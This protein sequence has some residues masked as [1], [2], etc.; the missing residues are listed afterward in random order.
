MAQRAANHLEA[1]S[2]ED[3]G[4]VVVP[5]EKPCPVQ[6]VS[7]T[8]DNLMAVG[9]DQTAGVQITLS[10]SPVQGGISLQ[11]STT[12]G[13]GSAKFN[14]NN[15]T[16]L[17]ISQT[18]TVTIKGVT[19]SSTANNIRLQAK[20]SDGS[21]TYA[22]KDFTVLQ[23]TLA[24]RDGS[25]GNVTSDNSG[26]VTYVIVLGSLTL[27]TFQSSGSGNHLW[28]TGVEIVGTVEPSNY[29][30]SITIQLEISVI[31]TF[32]DMSLKAV[33]RG[34]LAHWQFARIKARKIYELMTI[35]NLVPG[36]QRSMILMLQPLVTSGS[37]PVNTILRVRTNFRQWATVK[38][39]DGLSDVRVSADKTWFSR[40][41]ITKTGSGDVLRTDVSGDNVAGN[42]ATALTWNLQ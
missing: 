39:S 21:K 34:S 27:G 41:S 15:S 40:I 12:S 16:T 6:T 5:T 7:V 37:A 14:S 23:V 30:G 18:S 28:R 11:L 22:T 19:A 4:L 17:S 2:A 24:L 31:R 25:D 32:A 1:I 36:R 33:E 42:G 20:S 9:K 35:R 29:T 38:S 26:G 8:I 10:P 13:T 3:C